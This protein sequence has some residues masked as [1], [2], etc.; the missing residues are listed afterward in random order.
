MKVR[1]HLLPT[2]TTEYTVFAGRVG[3]V[4]GL[5]PAQV[6]SFGLMAHPIPFGSGANQAMI[7]DYWVE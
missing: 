4:T 5:T 3:H 7:V 1:W 2:T 6:H